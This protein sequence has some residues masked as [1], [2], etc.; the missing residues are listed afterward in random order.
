MLVGKKVV[1]GA[2]GAT[3]WIYCL[4]WVNLDKYENA[5]DLIAFNPRVSPLPPYKVFLEFFQDK[6]LSRPVVSSSCAHIP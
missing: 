2:R 3:L 1:K 5:R 6:L 4:F